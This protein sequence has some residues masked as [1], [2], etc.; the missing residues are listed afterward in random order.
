MKHNIDAL[1]ICGGKGTRFRAVFQ[2][3]PKVMA[4]IHGRPFLDIL[5]EHL[6]NNNLTKIILCLG[7]MADYIQKYYQKSSLLPYLFFSEEPVPMGTGGAIK[8]A[9][10]LIESENFIV[11]NGDSF[12]DLNFDDLLDFHTQK[13]EA[14]V[15][16]AL[17]IADERKD[18]GIISINGTS[19]LINSFQEKTPI[20][21]NTFM[22]AGVYVFNKKTLDMIPPNQKYSLEYDL[23]PKISQNGLYGFKTDKKVIDIGTPERYKEALNIFQCDYK[24]NKNKPL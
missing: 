20:G 3:V 10:S 22:N 1:I 8:N 13:N 5:I 15:S 9:E 19:G 18:V 2:N 6:L 17:T 11:A 16:M 14:L 4:D 23:F 24:N 12:C 21:P 7:Y